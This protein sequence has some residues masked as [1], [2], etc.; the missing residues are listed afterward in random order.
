VR[1]LVLSRLPVNVADGGSNVNRS[2]NGGKTKET[3]NE[4]HNS[5]PSAL[6]RR[7][8]SDSA[9]YP[10]H[11]IKIMG[12]PPEQLTE[13]QLSKMDP[14]DRKPLGKRGMTAAEKRDKACKIL[15][16]KIHD[17]F[18]GFAKRNGFIV[19]HSSPVKRSSIRSG[20]PDFLL[21]KNNLGLGI[22]F[23]VPP[24]NLTTEQINVFREIE[25]TGCQVIVC[26]ETEEGAAYAQAT[27]ETIKFFNLQNLPFND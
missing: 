6:A 11:Q 2:S 13:N 24:N 14:S 8:H 12:I 9:V 22:E 4:D 1:F 26:I 17:Q 3:K 25:V 5:S 16:R 15:E 27:R 7:H 19:W 20:L 10:V 23:K 21:W 18:S